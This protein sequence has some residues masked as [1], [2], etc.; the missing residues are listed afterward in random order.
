V[1][2]VRVERSDLEGNVEAPPSKSHTH[3]AIVLAS[4]ADGKSVIRNPLLSQDCMATIEACR[5]VGARIGIG[6]DRR[7][8]GVAGTP[9][10][11]GK[12]DVG[13]SGTTLRLM[14]G[15][16]SLCGGETLL[17]GD[18]SIRKRP[19]QPLLDSLEELGASANSANENGCAPVRVRGKM[20]GGRTVI[21]GESSQF[22]SSLLISC[23]L[24]EKGSEVVSTCEKSEGYVSMTLD[25][26][27]KAGIAVERDG[28]VFRIPGKQ[29]PKPVNETVPGDFSSSAFL[30][31][32]GAI[33]GD[34]TVRRLDMKDSQP[35]R[36]IVEIL[37]DMGGD[38]MVKR[39]SVRVRKSE[40]RET[41][42]D[43]SQN[44]DLL[45]VL[46]V[47]ACFAEG[48]TVLKNVEHA[49]LK[50]SDRIAV[51]LKELRKMN[52]KVKE[53]EDG[54]EIEKSVLKGAEVDSHDDH[55]VAMALV[56][57]ALG[58]RGTTFVRDVRCAD[59]SFPG[60]IEKMRGLGGDIR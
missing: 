5:A 12:I 16:C 40:L 39:D 8:R 14:A 54:L 31:V 24:A 26:L 4:L 17:D 2:T 29:V 11:A 38:V 60:F 13:N 41:E 27:E 6:E 44:P 45:P 35:D 37:R 59:V 57:A 1:K 15:V 55:R 23:P 10:A 50:E 51:M 52:A 9:E 28:N 18:E 19:M 22:V 56:V 7:I 34:I 43:L 25:K 53:L 48:R 47:A 46:A 42:I 20:R 30:L 21:R 58:T 3:R 33:C 32:A 49:R 36:R